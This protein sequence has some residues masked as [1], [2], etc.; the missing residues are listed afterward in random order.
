M[1][2]VIVCLLLNEDEGKDDDS[3]DDSYSRKIAIF[4]LFFLFVC[5]MCVCVE[6]GMY[7]VHIKQIL[8][9]L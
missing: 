1:L 8:R 3:H 9:K 6:V 2:Y 5:F 4:N 7:I